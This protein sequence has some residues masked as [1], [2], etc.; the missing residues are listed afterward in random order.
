MSAT[1]SDVKGMVFT[2]VDTGMSLFGDNN[3]VYRNGMASAGTLGLDIFG[4][5]VYLWGNWVTGQPAAGIGPPS[6]R[7]PRRDAEN[8]GRVGNG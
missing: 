6:I 8:L 5:D 4:N 2:N 3:Y 1:N 7:G